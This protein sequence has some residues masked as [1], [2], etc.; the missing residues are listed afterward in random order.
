M[1]SQAVE[2]GEPRV[3]VVD[4]EDIEYL[5]VLDV[6]VAMVEFA[7]YNIAGRDENGPTLRANPTDAKFAAASSQEITVSSRIDPPTRDYSCARPDF[8]GFVKWDDCFEIRTPN[9]NVR[10]CD[11]DD[12]ARLG[13]VIAKI[14][15]LA[16]AEL[17]GGINA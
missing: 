14:Y 3:V 1:S 15:E 7:I 17:S 16:D 2:P 10:F 6:Y 5:V 9:G 8:E 12:A 4:C 13:K 11:S